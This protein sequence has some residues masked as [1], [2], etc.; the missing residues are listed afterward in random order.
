MKMKQKVIVITLLIFL[1]SLIPVSSA[2]YWEEKAELKKFLKEDKTNHMKKNGLS[3]AYVY[4]LSKNASE[5]NIS[6]GRVDFYNRD[7]RSG[8]S[9]A[10]YKTSDDYWIFIDSLT[11]GT[12]TYKQVARQLGEGSVYAKGTYFHYYPYSSFRGSGEA[13]NWLTKSA[14]LR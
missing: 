3:A 8:W 4:L 12:L 9:F 6:L 14:V 1:I 11:D 2:E 13:P 5:Y 7:I 10:Y